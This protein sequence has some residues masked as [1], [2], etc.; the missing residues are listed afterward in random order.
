MLI[1][2]MYVSL[3]KKWSSLSFFFV[4]N[5]HNKALIGKMYMNKSWRKFKLNS[6]NVYI[7]NIYMLVS[8]KNDVLCQFLQVF[9]KWQG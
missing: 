6:G 2:N 1:W 8:L 9:T 7:E 3:S 4:E 5:G